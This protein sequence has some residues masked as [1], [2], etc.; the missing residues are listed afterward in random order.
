MADAI[1]RQPKQAFLSTAFRCAPLSRSAAP[2]IA[3]AACS[4]VDPNLLQPALIA[5]ARGGGVRRNT[6]DNARGGGPNLFWPDLF[7]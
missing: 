6:F 5:A 7:W 1:F 3:A 2:N 4:R